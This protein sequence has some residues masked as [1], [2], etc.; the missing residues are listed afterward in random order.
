MRL[1]LLFKNEEKKIRMFFFFLLIVSRIKLTYVKEKL[2][3]IIKMI[4]TFLFS[5]SEKFASR[6]KKMVL[7]F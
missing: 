7:M 5:L 3:P 2:V 4:T 6:K 1:F